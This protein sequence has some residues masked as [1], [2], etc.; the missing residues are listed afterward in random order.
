MR[1]KKIGA[2][3]IIALAVIGVV[4]VAYFRGA[5]AEAVYPVERAGV[6]LSRRFLSR[7]GG[8]WNGGAAAVENLRLRR[9][10]AALK[11]ALEDRARIESE[12]ARLRAALKFAAKEPSRWIAASV[13][14]VGGPAAGVGKTL[15]LDR[16]SLAGV[17]D[18]AVVVVPEGLV[19]RV[20]FVTPHTSEVTLITDPSIKVA[21][22]AESAR[23][24]RGIVSGG[25]EEALVV[26]YL[27]EV[28]ESAQG[29]RVLTSG[30][31]G[32]FPAGLTIGVWQG[33]GSVEGD[34]PTEGIVKPSV[35]FSRLE[36]V[37]IRHEG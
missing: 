36:D 5:A 37:F 3:E 31:G 32:V 26:R 21:C 2:F 33:Y 6:S 28:S 12:N 9:E 30:L 15:R 34:R 1:N 20:T 23:G 24:V 29:S 16:G 11:L 7:L 27:T 35:D 4:V 8:C 10:T 19:G 13:F 14:S 18:G 25:S 17:T 22:V